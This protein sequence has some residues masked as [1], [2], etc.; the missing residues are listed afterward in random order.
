[1][2][3]VVLATEMELTPGDPLTRAAGFG[4]VFMVLQLAVGLLFVVVPLGVLIYVM[5]LLRRLTAAVQGIERHLAPPVGHGDP[6]TR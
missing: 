1:M 4:T 5:V 2:E 3:L 6:P